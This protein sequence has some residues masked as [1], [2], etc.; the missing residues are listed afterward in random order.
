MKTYPII[1]LGGT[2]GSGKDTVANFL[3]DRFGYLFVSGSGLLRQEA[4]RR[5]LPV[6]REV[7]RSI[8]AEWR[9][10]SGLGVIIDK[11]VEAYES[12]SEQLSG[13]VIASLRN[14]G[15]A[16]RVHDF[17]G[18][19][20]WIDADAHIRYDRIQRNLVSRNRP[21]EDN[22]TFEEFLREE[23]DEMHRPADG[24]SASLDGAAVKSRSDETLMNDSNDLTVLA[25]DLRAILIKH[26]LV[27][28]E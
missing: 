17:G 6:E 11:A 20:I 1:G 22:K 10:Q 8:S 23:A 18:L 13:L 15:E 21:E 26:K 4:R 7:L 3:V 16:D 28:A 24:D 25:E 19:V 2:N 5:D 27:K 12:S 14:P 9:R